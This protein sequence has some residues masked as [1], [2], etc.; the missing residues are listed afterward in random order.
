M[1]KSD[2][3]AATLEAATTAASDKLRDLKFVTYTRTH[4]ATG[5]VYAGRTS[6]FGSAESLVA[7]RAARHPE[8]LDGF[9]PAVVD[10]VARGNAQGYMAVRGREQQLI[11]E[12]G[13]AQSEG[14]TSA[15]QIR[16]VARPIVGPFL[17]QAN[18]PANWV[19][20]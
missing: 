8:R 13:K 20:R 4:P 3:L 19:R 9:G 12:H 10:R 17:V 16:A 15:N 5:Q 14:G 7:A 1:L 11:D 6:G 2:E 18:N